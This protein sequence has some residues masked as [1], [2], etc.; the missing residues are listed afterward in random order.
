MLLA[1]TYHGY[2]KQHSVIVPE[3][4][5]DLKDGSWGLEDRKHKKILLNDFW[6]G[7]ISMHLPSLF[8]QEEKKSNKYMKHFDMHKVAMYTW[9]GQA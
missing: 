3:F 9:S 5:H 7:T 2:K 6:K 4:C 1:L 8:T